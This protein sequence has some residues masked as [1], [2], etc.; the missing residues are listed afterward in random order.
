[1]NKTYGNLMGPMI[2]VFDFL[3]PTDIVTFSQTTK[4][5]YDVLVPRYSPVWPNYQRMNK[6]VLDKVSETHLGVSFKRVV[7]VEKPR[8]PISTLPRFGNKFVTWQEHPA[9]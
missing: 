9:I 1:M 5:A 2:S 3:E 8:F 7:S 6:G 4:R